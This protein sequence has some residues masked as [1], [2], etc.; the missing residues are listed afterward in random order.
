MRRLLLSL[1]PAILLG[2]P[3]ASAQNLR[4][5]TNLPGCDFT[6]GNLQ[7]SC[8]PAF[9]GHLIQL[10]FGLIS[11]LFLLNV[12]YAGY[13]IALGYIRGEKAE[14]IERL[15]WS[16]LGL[17]ISVCAFLILDLAVSVISPAA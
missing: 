14:G 16:I 2:I 13:Q 11:I 8:I 1:P 12:M 5:I 3:A 15:R 7:A 6:T 10:V 4:V 17:I 9:I